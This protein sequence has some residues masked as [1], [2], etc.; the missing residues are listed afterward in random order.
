MLRTNERSGLAELSFVLGL[1]AVVVLIVATSIPRMALVSLSGQQISYGV[2]QMRKDG[3]NGQTDVDC[4]S[5]EFSESRRACSACQAFCI[6]AILLTAAGTAASIKLH[7]IF[8]GIDKVGSTLLLAS[9]GV[10]AFLTFIV[11]ETGILDKEDTFKD[12]KRKEAYFLFIVSAVMCWIS[13]FALMRSGDAV[14]P[15]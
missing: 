2:W 15:A 6:I 9:G 5:E 14:A 3:E 12:A 13:S 4:T 1:L 11:Y 8:D 7:E 10:A